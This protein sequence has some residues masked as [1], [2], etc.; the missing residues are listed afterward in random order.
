MATSAASAR[1]RAAGLRVT[2]QRVAILDVLQGAQPLHEHLTV[3]AIAQRA[4]P[5]VRSLSLQTAYDCLDALT[6]AGLLRAIEPAGHPVRYEARVAD[7]HHHLVCRR[8]GELTDVDDVIG[9]DACL[10]PHT[11]AGF[12]VDTTEVTFWGLCPSCVASSEPTTERSFHA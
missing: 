2:K 5:L 6:E 12:V 3:A 4:R 8:C 11:T 9:V 7:D 10:T 1:L